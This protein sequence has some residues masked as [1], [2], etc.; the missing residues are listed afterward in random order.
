MAVEKRSKRL[1]VVE[2]LAEKEELDCAKALGEITDQLHAAQQQLQQLQDYLKEYQQQKDSLG[3]VRSGAP[4]VLANFMAFFQQLEGAIRQQKIN[5]ERL[6]A[7]R[8]MLQAEWARRH[9]KRKN[10]QKLVSRYHREEMNEEE[11]R[12]QKTLD[13][14]QYKTPFE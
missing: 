12:L 14:R 4:A 2:Q 5:V 7:Q 1:K 10:Y 9:N 8:K 6:E 13:D 11:K 3:T